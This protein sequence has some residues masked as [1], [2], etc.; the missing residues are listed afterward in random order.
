MVL[1]TSLKPETHKCLDYQ[2]SKHLEWM[3]ETAKIILQVRS[4]RV[5]QQDLNYLLDIAQSYMSHAQAF[6]INSDNNLS[7]DQGVNFDLVYSS[8]KEQCKLARN[9]Q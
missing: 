2:L 7:R 6:R 3:D 4:M 8:L 5:P 9:N 1:R